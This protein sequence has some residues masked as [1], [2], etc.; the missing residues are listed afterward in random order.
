[1]FD[2]KDFENLQEYKNKHSI[3]DV[4]LLQNHFFCNDKEVVLLKKSRNK[5][6]VICSPQCKEIPLAQLQVFDVVYWSTNY[7]EALNEFYK[8]V[9]HVLMRH[10]TSKFKE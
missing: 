1:M 7:E 3:D 4:S 9:L 6:S 10:T 5:Y 2:F 8:C